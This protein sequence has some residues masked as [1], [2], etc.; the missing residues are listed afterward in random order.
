MPEIHHAISI[1]AS[2]DIV[3]A[4][5]STPEGFRQWWAEDVES[6]PDGTVSLGFFN[7]ATVYRLRLV[8]K[9]ARRITWHCESGQEWQHTDLVFHLQPHSSDVLLDF[10]H[11]NWQDPTPYF[12]SCNTTWGALMFRLKNAA[13]GRVAGPMFRK[14]SMAY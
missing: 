11:A 5:V 6:Q 3:D 10:L 14:D 1:N 8:E 2:V 12:V 4:L 7:R 9:S 13:E